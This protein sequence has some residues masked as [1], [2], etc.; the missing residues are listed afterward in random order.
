MFRRL[1]R[2]RLKNI[3]YC[4]Y[5]LRLNIVN[6]L[7]RVVYYGFLEQNSTLYYTLIHFVSQSISIMQNEK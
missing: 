4:V 7:K 3:N 5:V 6:Q 1:Y 2:Y